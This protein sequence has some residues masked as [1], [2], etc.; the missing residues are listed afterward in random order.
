MHPPEFLHAWLTARAP[1]RAARIVPGDRYR[2]VRALEIALAAPDPVEAG[3]LPKTFAHFVYRKFALEVEQPVLDARIEAR[4][5]AML[6]SGFLEEAERIG[7]GAV[8]ADAVGY[9]QAL[10]F[11]AGLSSAAELRSALIRATRRYGKR[12]RTWFR[13]EP[14]TTPVPDHDALETLTRLAREMPGWA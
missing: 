4:V 3:R 1:E 14:G 9:P 8:A 13:G 10:A 6:K 11:L 7:A 12:Q 2:V 5:E